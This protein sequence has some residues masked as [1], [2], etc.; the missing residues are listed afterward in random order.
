MRIEGVEDRILAMQSGN[1]WH[2]DP[3]ERRRS[4]QT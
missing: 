4:V 3:A 2:S 1:D